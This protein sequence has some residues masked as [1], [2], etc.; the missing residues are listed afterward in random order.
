M[1]PR[2]GLEPACPF[3]RGILSPLCI[4]F[5]HQGKSKTFQ[6]TMFSARSLLRMCLIVYHARHSALEFSYCINQNWSTGASRPGHFQ[7]Q[8]LRLCAEARSLSRYLTFISMETAKACFPAPST[9]TR[10]RTPSPLFL[11]CY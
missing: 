5:H 11:L 7:Q 2:A 1:V 3:E 10:T 8:S 9:G 6:H 4:P